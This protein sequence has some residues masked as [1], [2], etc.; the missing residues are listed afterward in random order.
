MRYCHRCCFP[1]NSK[2]YIIFDEQGICS[3][4]RTFEQRQKINWSEKQKE[5]KEI[6]DVYKEKTQK[7]GTLFDCIIPVSGGKDSHYQVY[8]ITQV[9]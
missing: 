3:G 2:P 9:F 1:E 8:M 5:F 4:C 6:L 7:N